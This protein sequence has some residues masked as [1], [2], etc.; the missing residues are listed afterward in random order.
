MTRGYQQIHDGEWIEPTRKYIDQCCDCGLTHRYVFVVVDKDKRPI[1]GATIQMKLTVDHR[2]TAAS[3][4]K[5]K[6]S[7]EKD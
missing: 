4:R 6:F 5:L 3:R 7:K 1:K 2:L